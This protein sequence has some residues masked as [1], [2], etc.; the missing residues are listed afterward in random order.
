M[1]SADVHIKLWLEHDGF[2]LLGQGP[3]ELLSR[4]A[5]MGSLRK[6]AESMNMS[7][8]AAWGRLKRAEDAL[9]CPLVFA[10]GN[11]REGYQ[12]T[13]EGME[14]VRVYHEWYAK[15]RDCALREAPDISFVRVC[16]AAGEK[17]A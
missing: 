9:G 8:R 11:R 10:S 5:D 6:A 15:V 14:M 13:P 17:P 2:M 1:L 7:Y 3:V 4:I 12:L 16:G